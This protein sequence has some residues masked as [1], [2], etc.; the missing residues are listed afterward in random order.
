VEKVKK[1]IEIKSKGAT[2]AA[3][4]LGINEQK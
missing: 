2:L 4:V 3:K 1:L